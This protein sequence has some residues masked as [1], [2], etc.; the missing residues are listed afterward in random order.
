MY[1]Y[2]HMYKHLVSSTV[3]LLLYCSYLQKNMAFI[4]KCVEKLIFMY[5]NLVVSVK[6]YVVLKKMKYK[7][8]LN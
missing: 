8:E 7:K 4:W 5:K 2:L 1:V 3:E 6:F